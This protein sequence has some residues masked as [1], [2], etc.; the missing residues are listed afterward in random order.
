MQFGNVLLGDRDVS[1]A[2]QQERLVLGE[3]QI[4]GADLQ[5]P[6]LG[7]QPRYPQRRP[8]SAS[9]GQ[10]GAARYVIGQHR[11][12][13]LAFPVAQHVHVVQDQRD[14]RGH[15][16]ERRPE[17]RQDRA[18][19]RTPRRGQRVEDP[20][21]DRLDRIQRL[22]D[23]GEQDLRIVVPFVDRY[24]GERLAVALGPLR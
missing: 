11:Q 24:P 2:Q 15:Q 19:H 6:S 7:A 10:P 9:Q 22:R 8:G 16:G 23:I 20:L 14:R 4:P 13:L 18:G 17:P 21:V 12:R 5:D 3:R 1:V